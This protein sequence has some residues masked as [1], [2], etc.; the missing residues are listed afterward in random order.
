MNR[1]IL[2]LP[3]L[4][5]SLCACGN[6]EAAPPAAST[7]EA[8]AAPQAAATAPAASE[9][10]AADLTL[11]VPAPDHSPHKLSMLFFGLPVLL[12]AERFARTVRRHRHPRR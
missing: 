4:L 7:A 9:P 5:L 11:G 8:S 12:R 1:S 2:I 3:F 10:Q 6:R